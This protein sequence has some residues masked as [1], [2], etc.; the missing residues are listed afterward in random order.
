[1]WP[2]SLAH[3]AH[4]YFCALLG[5]MTV[6]TSPV[7]AEYLAGETGLLP[8]VGYAIVA[9]ILVRRMR[10]ASPAPAGQ[11]VRPTINPRVEANQPGHA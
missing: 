10:T 8:I 4:N 5:S 1:M 6:A 3:S 7:A 11:Q 9:A 2:A